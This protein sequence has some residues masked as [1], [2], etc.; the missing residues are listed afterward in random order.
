MSRALHPWKRRTDSAT[1]KGSAVLAVLE[2]SEGAVI[3]RTT[4]APWVN[5][6]GTWVVTVDGISTAVPLNRLFLEGSP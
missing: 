5:D 4:S 1:A 2:R 6:A 3:T